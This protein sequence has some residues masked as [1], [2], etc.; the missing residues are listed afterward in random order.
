MSQIGLPF[1]WPAEADKSDFLISAANSAAA[2]HLEHWS[3]WPV[4]ASVLIGP[5]KSGRSLLGRIFAHNTGGHVIDDAELHPEAEVFHAWNE[6]QESRK[7]LLIIALQPPIAWPVR[8]P[9]LKSR[10]G[11]TPMVHI[12]DPDLDL[13]T[14]LIERLLGRRGIAISPDVARFIATRMERGYVDIQRIVDAL[15]QESLSAR[16]AITI[17]FARDQLSKLALIDRAPVTE[18]G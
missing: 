16:R 15:D 6:A 1:D 4:K 9:D 3:R 18:P 5:R 14:Q 7:P 2:E 8:L 11:A 17:P 13:C 10:L 12:G